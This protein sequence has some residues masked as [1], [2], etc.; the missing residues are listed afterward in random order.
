MVEQFESTIN[1]SHQPRILYLAKKV[2]LKWG[3][4]KDLFGFIK[5]KR[6]HSLQTRTTENTKKSSSGRRKINPMEMCY[7]LK[8]IKITGKGSIWQSTKGFFFIVCL[9]K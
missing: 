7:L 6:I 3:W 5:D 8:E 4:N 9:Q 1:K 2:F